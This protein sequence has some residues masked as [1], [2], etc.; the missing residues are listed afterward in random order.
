M[1]YESK[2]SPASCAPPTRKPFITIHAM[3]HVFLSLQCPLQSRELY[4]SLGCNY[5][6]PLSGRKFD[7]VLVTT[8]QLGS[9]S[10][11]KYRKRILPP[12]VTDPLRWTE[13]RDRG[14]EYSRPLS[15]RV[16]FDL[17][18]IHCLLIGKTV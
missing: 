1:I 14:I 6:T 18:R 9:S 7:L 4:V 8:H 13:T 15:I 2:C 16:N 11:L 5:G 17:T 10:E 12:R 3:E